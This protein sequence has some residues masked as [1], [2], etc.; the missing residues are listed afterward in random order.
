MSHHGIQYT[1][2]YHDGY[3]GTLGRN[4]TEDPFYTL[5]DAITAAQRLSQHNFL[6]VGSESLSYTS[7]LIN[8]GPQ[9]GCFVFDSHSRNA[10]G[11][12]TAD[13]TS[14]LVALPSVHHV[15]DH[16]H[17]LSTYLQLI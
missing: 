2:T 14:V 11:M 1:L 17:Q 8:L 7:M 16:I 12:A 9:Q 13:G 3:C 5:A 10:R 4:I 15:A 6:L